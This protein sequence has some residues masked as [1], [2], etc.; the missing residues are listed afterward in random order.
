MPLKKS[1]KCM[2]NVVDLHEAGCTKHSS[3]GLSL[4]FETQLTITIINRVLAFLF[5]T[6]PFYTSQK[7]I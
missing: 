7:S 1:F 2:L 3:V 6:L 5:F 4:S